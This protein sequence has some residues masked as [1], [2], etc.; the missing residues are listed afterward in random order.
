M[1]IQSCVYKKCNVYFCF[2]KIRIEYI[3]SHFIFYFNSFFSIFLYV[4]SCVCIKYMCVCFLKQ[5]ME[6]M[7]GSENN[8]RNQF[9]SFIMWV[10][11]TELRHLDMIRKTF[12]HRLLSS[13]PSLLL[14]HVIHDLFSAAPGGGSFLFY[15][16]FIIDMTFL[17]W[18]Q[19]QP[20]WI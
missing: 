14:K 4:L 8:H 5:V 17:S 10:Q 18:S 9:S 7:C 1:R 2:I 20:I 16:A 13:V 3:S 6:Y 11:G 12:T 15:S 19:E